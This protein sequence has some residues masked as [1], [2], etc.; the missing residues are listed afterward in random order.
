MPELHPGIAFE[1][2]ISQEIFGQLKKCDEPSSISLL[3]SS[4]VIPLSA[5]KD[6]EISYDLWKGI[7][8]TP[9]EN[10]SE[11]CNPLIPF[12][13]SSFCDYL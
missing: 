11:S 5:V 2:S 4:A 9:L 1:R 10:S 8:D 3:S 13:L 7:D 6:I 12:I